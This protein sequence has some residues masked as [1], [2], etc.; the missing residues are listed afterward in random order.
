V[1]PRSEE[2]IPPRRR[3]KADLDRSTHQLPHSLGEF[4]TR[5]SSFAVLLFCWRSVSRYARHTCAEREL[6]IVQPGTGSTPELAQN[7]PSGDAQQ[8]PSSKSGRDQRAGA[9]SPAREQRR[10]TAIH[11]HTTIVGNLPGHG[12]LRFKPVQPAAADLLCMGTG[13]TRFRLSGWAIRLSAAATLETAYA[14]SRP[15]CTG[16]FT[17]P[18]D[19]PVRCDRWPRLSLLPAAEVLHLGP[20]DGAGPMAIFPATRMVFRQSIRAFTPMPI[21]LPRA[22]A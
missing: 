4:R 1:K 2:A 6:F 20:R 8:G 17:R 16:Y 9:D 5:W 22:Q 21:R 19:Q 11:E 7:Q 18:R 14:T 10:S 12:Y 13:L 3:L 15:T